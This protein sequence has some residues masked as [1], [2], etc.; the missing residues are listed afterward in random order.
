VNAV[1]KAAAELQAFCLSKR[2]EFCFIGGLA[3]QAWGQPRETVDADLTLLTGFGGEERF[4]QP[5]IQ[6]FPSR[7]SGPLDFALQH[8]VVLLKSKNGVGLDIALGALP[9]EELA[10]KRSILFAFPPVVELRICTAEDLIVMKAFASRA[11]DW[12]DIERVVIRQ[13]RGLDWRYIRTHLMPLLELKGSTD[14][15]ERLEKLRR[16]LDRRD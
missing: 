11:Q 4:I 7:I 3:L 2:W 1:I 16:D 15:A 13:G 10:V 9:F 5:L 8:R 6:E 12:V 14:T